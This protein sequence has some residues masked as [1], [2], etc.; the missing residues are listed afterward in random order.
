MKLLSFIIVLLVLVGCG[1]SETPT[2]K[3]P[4]NTPPSP[5]PTQAVE[6]DVAQEANCF[7]LIWH[8]HA[9]LVEQANL[10]VDL[11]RRAWRAW[12]PLLRDH[13]MTRKKQTPPVR[14]SYE[15]RE[16]YGLYRHSIG[17]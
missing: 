1:T 14:R 5:A 9:T 6:I 7:G 3:L 11:S 15:R 13:L 12:V 4:T 16:G 8:R 17:S 10:T 2:T